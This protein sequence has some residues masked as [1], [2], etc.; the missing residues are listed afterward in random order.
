MCPKNKH[1]GI[2]IHMYLKGGKIKK[3][4]SVIPSKYLK[5]YD[6]DRVLIRAMPGEVIIPKKYV[7]KITKYLKDEKI[8]L[9]NM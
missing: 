9:P 5:P 1:N 3:T 6:R 8:K 4:K 2:K 7:K